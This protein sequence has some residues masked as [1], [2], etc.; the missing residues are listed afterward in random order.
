M[1]MNLLSLWGIRRIHMSVAVI[2]Q[3]RYS[4]DQARDV[5]DARAAILN[6]LSEIERELAQ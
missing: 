1:T 3:C 5:Y 4:I 6:Q 2:L